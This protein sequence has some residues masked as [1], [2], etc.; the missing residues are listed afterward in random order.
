MITADTSLPNAGQRRVLGSIAD[1]LKVEPDY[2]RAVAAALGHKLDTVLV[3]T[4]GEA[5]DILTG[6]DVAEATLLPVD[7]P[8]AEPRP[9]VARVRTVRFPMRDGIGGSG[10]AEA[11]RNSRLAAGDEPRDAE[12]G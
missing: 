12:S 11:E 4:E 2:E 5:L 6:S 7:Q 1:G 3:G 9:A 10:C 8:K